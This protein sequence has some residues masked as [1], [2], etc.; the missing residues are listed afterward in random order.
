[1]DNL[2]VDLQI[3]PD[4]ERWIRNNPEF[5]PRATLLGLR[6]VTRQASKEIKQRIKDLGLIDTGKLYKSVKGST[7]KTKSVIGTRSRI[8]NILEHGASPHTIVPKKAKALHFMGGYAK[9]VN[10]PG[11]AK[12]EYFDEVWEFMYGT[13]EVQSLFAAGVQKAIEAIENGS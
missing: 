11:T 12:Y 2:R 8:A 13:G 4:I 5:A 6:N 10:H 1:M 3:S 9:S 7:T